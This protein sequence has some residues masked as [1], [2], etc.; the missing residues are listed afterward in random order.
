MS[1]P[2]T[3]PITEPIAV[4]AALTEPLPVGAAP[5]PW[6]RLSRPRTVL[7][8]T[9]P[10]HPRRVLLRLGAGLVAVL[11]LVGLLGALAAGRLAEREAVNDAANTAD[12]L[13]EAVIQ[14]ALTEALADGDPAAVRTF[15]ALVRERVLGATVVRVK[16]WSPEGTVVYA[17]EPQLV[18]RSFPLDEDQRVALSDPQT[19]AEVSDLSASEN[20]FES[21][22]RLLE[23][24]RPVWTP[25]GRELLFEMYSPYAPVE[26][27]SS[28]LWRGFAGVT[29]SS[30][31]LVVVLTAP[32]V[33][34]LLRRLGEDE[35]L[36]AVLLQRAVD[37]SDA[38]RRRVAATLHDGPVQELVATTFAAE[39][40]AASAAQRGEAGLADEMRLVASSVR[41]NIRVL[42]SL[43]VDIYP[44]TLARAG[45]PQALADLGASMRGRQVEVHTEVDP[46][47]PPLPE[48]DERLIHR[49]AQEC[50]RN[51]AAH[52]APCSVGV[53]VTAEEGAVVLQVTDDGAGFDP[54]SLASPREGHVGTRVLADLATELG[55]D[56]E[57]ASAPG[58]GTRWRLRVPLQGGA[59]TAGAGQG[60]PR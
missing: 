50:L 2:T 34:R 41:G 52:A 26:E 42:R 5:P 15:D 28:Q 1:Q 7:G 23:V 30:L 18:G 57:V 17:D 22:G 46:S 58:A 6:V 45:L 38:E 55:A 10:V 13:A 21:G 53:T 60:G 20:E 3:P 24:Y 32:I 48:E 4:R 16:V 31:L 11:V 49:V 9:A 37:A 47:L 39:G 54:A 40:A 19:R 44:A 29:L 59:P 8:P 43:L 36:R 35:R 25:G 27:R 14:P 12:V 33:W 56:L 51:A